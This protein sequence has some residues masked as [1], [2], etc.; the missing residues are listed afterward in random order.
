M[1]I[2]KRDECPINEMII[3]SNSE[4]KYYLSKGYQYIKL[5]DLSDDY[6]LY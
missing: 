5:K 4:Y 6:F 1:C 3:D 2:P